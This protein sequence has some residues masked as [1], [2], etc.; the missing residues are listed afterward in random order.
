MTSTHTGLARQWKTTVTGLTDEAILAAVEEL[1]LTVPPPGAPRAT[2][3]MRAVLN[4]ARKR[5]I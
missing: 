4:E 3:S 1:V 5:G 2:S